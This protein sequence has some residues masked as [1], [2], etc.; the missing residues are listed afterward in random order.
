MTNSRTRLLPLLPSQ[1]GMLAGHLQDPSGTAYSEAQIVFY[2]A[3]GLTEDMVRTA[4][5]TM[6]DEL[7][8]VNA[9]AEEGEDGIWRIRLLDP[10]THPIPITRID[11]SGEEDPEAAARARVLAD[12]RVPLDVTGPEAPVRVFHLI[13]GEGSHA[14]SITVNHLFIDGY[15]GT[16]SRVRFAA[17]IDALLAGDPIPPSPFGRYADLVA[18]V[19]P[20]DP[21]DLEFWKK[22]LDGAP[23]VL[24]PSRTVVPPAPMYARHDVRVPGFIARFAAEAPDLNWAFA[25]G[26][27]AAAYIAALTEEDATVLGFPFAGRFTPGEKMT[28]SQ[29]M[30]S[31]PLHV[32][33]DPEG[34]T[35]DLARVFG[36]TVRSTRAHQRQA[37]HELR[38]AIPAAL[39]T[40]RIHGPTVNVIPF[41]MPAPSPHETG[42]D[43]VG[44]GP[45]DDMMLITT[46][47]SAGG[48]LTK[49]LFNPVLHPAGERALHAERLAR[50]MRAVTEHPDVPIR[51]SCCLTETEEYRHEEL[52]TTAATRP[53]RTP[54]WGEPCTVAD[55]AAAAGVEGVRGI[56]LV[57]VGGRPPVFGAPGR[58]T[59]HT[60]DGDRE[61]DLLAAITPSSLTYRGPASE[62]VVVAGVR[63]ELQGVRAAVREAASGGSVEATVEASVEATSRRLTVHLGEGADAETRERVAARLPALVG[64]PVSVR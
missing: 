13:L 1:T 37:S 47:D 5:R 15:G 26:A 17:I 21:R 9:V 56:S 52:R 19:P 4:L 25:A 60:G 38:A 40:G 10:A 29:S 6:V 45:C 59:F 50:W 64:V 18:A 24:S 46:S 28:P 7:D 44:Y 30:V 51:R 23:E 31:L 12:L 49:F 41:E 43:V 42:W 62:R 54:A 27:A 33:V 58:V 8:S 16:L 55:L 63:V 48:I 14:W 53:P 32:P 57:T 36:A 61:S 35:L 39:R 34:S 20:A 3:E 22:H 2:A 11:V